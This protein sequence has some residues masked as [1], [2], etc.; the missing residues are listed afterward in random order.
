[1]EVGFYAT[2]DLRLSLG[3]GFG[4]VG[5]RDFTGSHSS[6]GVYLGFTAKVNQLFDG[7]G[8]ERA[9]WRTRAMPVPAGFKPAPTGQRRRAG[10]SCADFS[11]Q[12]REPTPGNWQL[13]RGHDMMTLRQHIHDVRAGA[14]LCL[15]RLAHRRWLRAAGTC[16]LLPTRASSG[17]PR[18]SGVAHGHLWKP[19]AAPDPAARLRPDW[20]VHPGRLLRRGN[21]Q[22]GHPDL[23][24]GPRHRPGR[25]RDTSRQRRTSR[26]RPSRARA[27]SRRAPRNWPGR[28]AQD[29]TGNTAG[30]APRL[31]LA[32]EDGIYYVV[33]YGPIGRQCAAGTDG[34]VGDITLAS[35]TDFNTTRAAAWPPGT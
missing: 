5:D 12:G 14:A 25:Q 27:R 2:P 19:A 18:Q 8:L 16:T 23:P 10:P 7:F 34:P 26:R 17:R 29:G 31:L 22:R 4:R 21:E 24:A 30:Y 6:G 3:Y 11:R 32:P 20:R 35:A 15:L 28:R 13:G 9:R 1:M 33:F